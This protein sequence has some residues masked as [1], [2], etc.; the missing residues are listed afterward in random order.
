M[1]LDATLFILHKSASATSLSVRKDQ[2]RPE[3]GLHL[4][5]VTGTSSGSLDIKEMND[6]V[7]SGEVSKA[8]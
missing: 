4:H 8:G 1:D 6:L 5:Y 2:T 3:S 7:N